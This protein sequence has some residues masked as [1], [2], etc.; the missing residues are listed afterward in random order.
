[1]SDRIIGSP[2]N[3]KTEFEVRASGNAFFAESYAEATKVWTGS[4][5]CGE[6]DELSGAVCSRQLGHENGQTSRRH[7]SEVDG[8][9][10]L[11]PA[12]PKLILPT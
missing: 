9:V 2:M 1:M 12:T 7:R 11:W 3:T 5:A 6:L 4:E 10:L 8:I